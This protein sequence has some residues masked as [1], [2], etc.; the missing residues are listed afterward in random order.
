VDVVI[1]NSAG[2]AVKHLYSGAAQ[3]LPG[4]FDLSGNLV[5]PGVPVNISLGGFLANGQSS[6]PWTGLNDGSQSVG[7]GV[8]TIKVSET[9]SFGAV[10]SWSQE[11]SVLPPASQE[12]LAIYNSAG[13]LITKLDTSSVLPATSTAQVTNVG[14]VDPTKTT[15]VVPDQAAGPGGVPFVLQLSGNGSPV[16]FTWNGRN[17]QGQE[18]SSGVYTV[19]L[20]SQAAGSSSIIL[21]SKG[22]TILD[23]PGNGGPKVTTGPNPLGPL[24]KS[25]T[26]SASGL[27]GTEVASVKLYNVAGELIAQGVSAAGQGKIMLTVGN[28]S[29]GVYLAVYEIRDSGSLKSRKLIKVA[30]SR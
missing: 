8:Y 23:A 26:F 1:Y 4:G 27:A 3:Q 21:D 18:V 30:I 13:E 28:W 24:D 5:A 14:F 10:Q 17:S 9:D 7:G 15:F 25:L 12:S 2:E 29:A 20:I 16:T 22:F 11:V 6:L 19:Q